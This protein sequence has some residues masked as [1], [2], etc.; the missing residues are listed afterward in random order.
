MQDGDTELE[1]FQ[2][3]LAWMLANLGPM[4]R[5]DAKAIVESDPTFTPADRVSRMNLLHQTPYYWAMM[6]LHGKKKP[7]W[8]K[9]PGNWPPPPELWQQY[10]RDKESGA[11][12]PIHAK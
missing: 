1:E 9:Q 10:D 6:H 4:S 11:W 3:E 5:D 12:R 8:Y 7:P 2:D